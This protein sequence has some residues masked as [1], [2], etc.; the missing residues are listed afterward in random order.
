[1]YLP[2]T[3]TVIEMHKLFLKSHRLNVSYIVYL[4]VF[5]EKLNIPLAYQ[6]VTH[7]Q[8]VIHCSYRSIQR[9][10]KMSKIHTKLKYVFWNQEDIKRIGLR[11]I[12]LPVSPSIPCRTFLYLIIKLVRFS[13]QAYFGIMYLESMTLG[14]MWS[15]WMYTM[16]WLPKKAR[17]M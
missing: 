12:R 7:V 3:L 15:V 16:K 5:K 9:K 1:M 13:M 8:S 6:K 2:E 11:G 14:L 10:L 4:K 17:M